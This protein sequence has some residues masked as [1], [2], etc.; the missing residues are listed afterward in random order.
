MRTSERRIRTYRIM[1]ADRRRRIC[2]TFSVTRGK[3]HRQVYMLF[4]NLGDGNIS[5][6]VWDTNGKSIRVAVYDDDTQSFYWDS[7]GASGWSIEDDGN[8]RRA[9]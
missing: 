5:F 2:S 6:Q 7:P 1:S 4:T 3:W 8:M 9:A